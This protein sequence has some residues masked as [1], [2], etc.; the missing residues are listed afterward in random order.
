M[1][2]KSGT[3][4]F[5]SFDCARKVRLG[6]SG[7]AAFQSMGRTRGGCLKDIERR[8]QIV[9]GERGER[10]KMLIETVAEVGY[11]LHLIFRKDR[12]PAQVVPLVRLFCLEIGNNFGRAFF[13]DLSFAPDQGAQMEY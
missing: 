11:W 1:S 10:D 7:A 3:G 9:R 2:S 6:S 8:P 4:S 12:K 5:D 13:I